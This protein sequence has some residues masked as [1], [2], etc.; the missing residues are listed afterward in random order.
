MRQ[1]PNYIYF[2][3]LLDQV[4]INYHNLQVD[5][6]SSTA[7]DKLKAMQ[8]KLDGMTSQL[9]KVKQQLSLSES[10]KEAP[11]DGRKCYKCGSPDHLANNPACPK[12]KSKTDGKNDGGSSSGGGNSGGNGKWKP[13][14]PGEPTSKTI[15][16]R[17]MHYCS[18]CRNGKGKW[19]F[20]TTPEHKGSPNSA[21]GST[22]PPAAANI[23]SM[24]H[25]DPSLWME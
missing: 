9:S 6:G 2:S 5:W 13:P 1:I 20:H 14:A 3:H 11:K 4:E 7:G 16:G 15:N 24:S 22:P 10:K 12:F 23:A 17:L 25:L 18:K 21:S 8:A 19:T